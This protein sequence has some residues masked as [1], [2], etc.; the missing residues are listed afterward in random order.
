MRSG[1]KV[2]QLCTAAPGGMRSVVEGYQ[3]DG[4]F[5][6]WNVELVFTHE[7][8][9]TR[10]KLSRFFTG[11]GYVCKLLI[12]REIGLLHCHV[13][14]RASF[15]RKSIFAT[16]ARQFKVAVILHIHGGRFRVFYDDQPLVVQHVIRY[17]LE[18]ADRVLVLSPTWQEFIKSIAPGANVGICRNYVEMPPLAHDTKDRT[19][20]NLLFLGFVGNLKG[21]HDLLAVLPEVVKSHPNLRLRVGG[22]GEIDYAKDIVEREGLTNYVEFLGWVS[23]DAKRDLLASADIFVLPSYKEGLPVSLLEAMS[24]GVP[25]ISTTVGSIPELI[26]DTVNGFLIN[27]GDRQALQ[28][29]LVLLGKD[30]GLRVEIGDKGRQT[31]LA[32]YSR[33]VVLPELEAVYSDLIS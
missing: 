12:N 10:L 1:I 27:P 20:I 13:S 28:S 30:A 19:V 3:R 16:L 4:L 2:I 6:R 5:G 14:M 7:F 17:Q 8:G 29:L 11:L 31:I 21:I 25:V 24:Y 33:Q 23:G 32:Q 9:S 26:D 18:K 22:N 15:W